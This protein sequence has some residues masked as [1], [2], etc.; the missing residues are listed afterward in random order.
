MVTEAR[1]DAAYHCGIGDLLRAAYL[2]NFSMME[3][4]KCKTKFPT[5]NEWYQT[6]NKEQKQRVDGH[7]SDLFKPW[8]LKA[9][10]K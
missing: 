9:E 7:L 6:L 4:G 2:R 3:R 1:R 8:I 5:F 10:S